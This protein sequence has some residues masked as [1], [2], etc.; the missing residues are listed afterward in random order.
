[1]VLAELLLHVRDELAE[2][3][4]VILEKGRIMGADAV[5]LQI[6]L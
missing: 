1:V 2:Q 4:K 5:S 3:L 6:V